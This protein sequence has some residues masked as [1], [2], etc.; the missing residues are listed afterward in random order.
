MLDKFL[1]KRRKRR[2]DNSSSKHLRFVDNLD[3]SC[4]KIFLPYLK[5]NIIGSNCRRHDCVMI[6][7]DFIDFE[8][9][10]RRFLS[11]KIFVDNKYVLR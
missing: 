6:P 8:N 10:H 5:G 9:N 1:C 7:F 4:R 11:K 2:M 3:E